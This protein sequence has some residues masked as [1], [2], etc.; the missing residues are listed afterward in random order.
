MSRLV[1]IPD[2]SEEIQEAIAQ[3]TEQLNWWL[4]K[5]NR[6]RKNSLR[7]MRSLQV[8]VVRQQIAELEKAFEKARLDEAVKYLGS[9][10]NDEGK[11]TLPWGRSQVRL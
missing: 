4:D 2:S 7:S 10:V 1:F 8:D 5:L 3:K 11:R 6:S 9:L